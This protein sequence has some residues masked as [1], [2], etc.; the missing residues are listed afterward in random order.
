MGELMIFVRY[1]EREVPIDLP[2][3][4]TVADLNLAAMHLFGGVRGQVE[5]HGKRLNNKD[6]LADAGLSMEATVE[7]VKVTPEEDARLSY[8]LFHYIATGDAEYLK[9]T[10]ARGADVTGGSH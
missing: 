9:I 10:I 5:L 1:I 2:L 4:G 6:T 7:F 8:S 3:D